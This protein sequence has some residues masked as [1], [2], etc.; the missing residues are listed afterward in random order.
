MG[1]KRRTNKKKSDLE[2]NYPEYLMKAFFSEKLLASASSDPCGSE[3]PGGAGLS[4]LKKRR[5]KQVVTS[6]AAKSCISSRSIS[7]TDQYPPGDALSS[8]VTV[9]RLC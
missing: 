2:E 5:R 4:G 8:K 7:L 1:K 6:L 9:S 3:G